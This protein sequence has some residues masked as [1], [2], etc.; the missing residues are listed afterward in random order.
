MI[1]CYHI[2]FKPSP[3]VYCFSCCSHYHFGEIRI[4]CFLVPKTTRWSTQW[5]VRIVRPSGLISCSYKHISILYLDTLLEHPHLIPHSYEFHYNLFL[6]HPISMHHLL[7]TTSVVAPIHISETGP[8]AFWFLWPSDDSPNGL[9]GLLD[10]HTNF[11]LIQTHFNH[12]LDTLL[13]HPHLIPYSH[14]PH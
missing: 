6:S 4:T 14:E 1:Y 8:P 13:E 2:H 5:I 10:H 12:C 3:L 7:Y 9:S 11:M